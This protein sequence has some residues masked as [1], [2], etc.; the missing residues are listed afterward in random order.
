MPIREGGG[1]KVPSSPVIL[2]PPLSSCSKKGTPV[3]DLQEFLSPKPQGDRKQ[4]EGKGLAQ[5]RT[6]RLR[7]R[8]RGASSLI[9]CSWNPWDGKLQHVGSGG[10]QVLEQKRPEPQPGHNWAGN[11]GGM[12]GITIVAQSRSKP[13]LLEYSC[14]GGCRPAAL[15]SIFFLNVPKKETISTGA[16][17]TEVRHMDKLPSYG[18]QVMQN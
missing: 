16:G 13:R 4:D 9:S 15:F 10:V 12:K 8:L 18:H 11:M 14:L 17:D 1:C 5:L 6:G 7:G 2:P 3:P